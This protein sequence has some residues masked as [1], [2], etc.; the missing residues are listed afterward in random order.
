[1]KDDAS[2]TEVDT[3]KDDLLSAIDKLAGVKPVPKPSPVVPAIKDKTEETKST[4]ATE[5]LRPTK[6][7]TKPK[8]VKKNKLPAKQLPQTGETTKANTWLGFGVIGLL[9]A[10]LG[11]KKK[12]EDE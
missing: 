12:K 8:L 10:V 1:A 11:I 9:L 5:N 4:I 3:A 2:Q 7:S 6:K